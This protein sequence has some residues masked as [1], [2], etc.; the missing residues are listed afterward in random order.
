MLNYRFRGTTMSC[1]ELPVALENNMVDKIAT[2]P[3]AR[4]KKHDT[5][6]PMEIR[7]A[8]KENGEKCD[9]R[10]RPKDHRPRPGG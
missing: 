2:V 5:S 1:S 3:T 6:A 9:P 10:R 4:G 7:M 8:A